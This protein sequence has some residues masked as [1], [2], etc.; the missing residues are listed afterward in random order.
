[1]SKEPYLSTGNVHFRQVFD[2]LAWGSMTVI[3]FYAATQIKDMAA[4][5]QDLNKNFAVMVERV[6]NQQGQLNGIDAR[7]TSLEVSGVRRVVS[8]SR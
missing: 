1:M 8:H 3:C 2:R 5:V 6:S 4:S 7:V